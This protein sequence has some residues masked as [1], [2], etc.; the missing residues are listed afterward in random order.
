MFCFLG[1]SIANM[2]GL[3]MARYYK[4][5]ESKERGIQHLP[6]LVFFASEQVCVQKEMVL[7]ILL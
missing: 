5:P 2:Y 4:Y 7:L 3:M 6:T 1:G